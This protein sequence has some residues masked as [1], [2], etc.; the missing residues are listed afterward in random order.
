VELHI[1]DLDKNDNVFLIGFPGGA[2]ISIDNITKNS[3]PR[4]E[5]GSITKDANY[6]R[7]E[8]NMLS[9]PGSSGSPIFDDCGKLCG[10]HNAG[11]SLSGYGVTAARNLEKLFNKEDFIHH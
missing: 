10:I 5:A 4:T 6:Q 11:S 2:F 9:I 1:E 7:L 8:H 3:S